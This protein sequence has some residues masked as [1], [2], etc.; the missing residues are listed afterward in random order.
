MTQE[1][2]VPGPARENNDRIT[3]RG[4]DSG[5]ARFPEEEVD[6]IA[7][8]GAGP[9][10]SLDTGR[11]NLPLV[12]IAVGGVIAFAALGFAH[13]APLAIGLLLVVA[14][15]IWAGVRR[16]SHGSGAGTGTTTVTRPE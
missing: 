7:H 8:P 2:E 12:V 4:Y 1:R 9:R 15:A 14:G 11:S 3:E 16:Q 13:V 5:F 6:P 10:G